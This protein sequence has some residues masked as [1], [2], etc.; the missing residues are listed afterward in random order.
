MSITCH[1]QN[2]NDKA[3]YLIENASKTKFIYTTTKLK[4]T[5]TEAFKKNLCEVK[6]LMR[7]DLIDFKSI[8]KCENIWKTF[9]IK[10]KRSRYSRMDQIK[11]VEDSL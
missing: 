10:T 7:E 1:S 8:D 2:E 4:T 11:F 5:N 6:V 9:K 3:H